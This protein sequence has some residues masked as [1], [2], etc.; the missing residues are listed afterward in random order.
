MN[1]IEVINET[2]E[3]IDEL[4]IISKLLE[5]AVDLAP[6]TSASSTTPTRRAL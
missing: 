5:Y 6:S 4:K 2:E 3:T 1:Q